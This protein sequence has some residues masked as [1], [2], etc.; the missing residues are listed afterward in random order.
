MKTH[1]YREVEEKTGISKST[2]IR[3]KRLK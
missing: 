2:L 3:E 1:S